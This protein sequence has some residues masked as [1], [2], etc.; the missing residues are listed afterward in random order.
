MGFFTKKQQS[1]RQEPGSP[2]V[3]GMLSAK[4]KWALRFGP[5]QTAPQR[6]M[7]P[8]EITASDTRT[9]SIRRFRSARCRTGGSGPSAWWAYTPGR[10][11]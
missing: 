10:R 1:P 8:S 6:P 7:D 2:A 9:W 3:I 11:R 5:R 4:R